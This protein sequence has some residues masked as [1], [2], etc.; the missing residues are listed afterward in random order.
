MNAADAGPVPALE[1]RGLTRSYSGRRV[2]DALD[3]R[4]ERGDAY[5]FLGPNGAGKTTTMRMIL[6]LIERDAGEV[7]IQGVSHGVQARAHLG[8]IVEQPRFWPYLNGLQN[9]RI[10]AAYNGGVPESRIWD[11]LGLVRLRDRALDPVRTYSQG[12]RQRLGIAQALLGEPTILMLDEPSNGLDPAGMREVRDLVR[13][14]KE[15]RGLTVFV[16]S[17]LLSEVEQLCNRVG[18][19]RDGRLV[20][21]GTVT[22]LLQP[23]ESLEDC[24]LRLT[25][26]AEGRQIR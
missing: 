7:W 6:G 9:L 22:E 4:V 25:G 20:A 23:G 5:G 8:G 11:L 24:F 12:M 1:T 18:I 2:V 3:L 19:L 10:L 13:H 17:H 21:E 26:A 14:L 15:E 16:S